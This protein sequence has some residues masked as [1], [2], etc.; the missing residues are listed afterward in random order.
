MTLSGGWFSEAKPVKFFPFVLPAFPLLHSSS[1]SKYREITFRRVHL[2]LVWLHF[3][4]VCFRSGCSSAYWQMM[5]KFRW[6][7]F[8]SRI[9]LFNDLKLTG[10]EILAQSFRERN[11]ILMCRWPLAEQHWMRT[12]LTT[13][14]K[15]LNPPLCAR[16]VF[17]CSTLSNED[18]VFFVSPQGRRNKCETINQVF[19]WSNL[20]FPRLFYVWPLGTVGRHKPGQLFD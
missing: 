9:R 2:S 11:W 16:K 20:Y 6:F 17:M 12:R 3:V 10:K 18:S 4:P 8:T 14:N 13:Q 1:R 15:S 19:G 5:T 7:F